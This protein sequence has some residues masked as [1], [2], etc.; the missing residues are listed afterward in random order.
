MAY[1]IPGKTLTRIAGASLVGSQ[2]RFVVQNSAGQ[3]V[4]P[5]AGA[6]AFGILQNAP[7]PGAAGTVMVDGVS[8]L[9]ASAAIAADANVA[10]TNDGRGVTAATGQ[11][12][13]AKAMQAAGGAGE[14]FTVLLRPGAR[15]TP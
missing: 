9:V 13:V 8:K 12:V 15:L 5:A 3:I 14:I 6:E 7:A 11:Y 1:E 4:A 2:Y 10:T